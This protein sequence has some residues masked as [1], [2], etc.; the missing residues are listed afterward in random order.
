MIGRLGTARSLAVVD[1]LLPSR[2]GPPG[3]CLVVVTWH[4]ISLDHV[5]GYRSVDARIR[6]D[7]QRRSAGLSTWVTVSIESQLLDYCHDP[8]WVA[9][10][11]PKELLEHC[12]TGPKSSEL[13][14]PLQATGNR[15]S[16]EC[17]GVFLFGE[18]GRAR[19]GPIRLFAP[20]VRRSG[21]FWG[22]SR[23]LDLRCF[24]WFLVLAFA[25]FFWHPWGLTN[26]N[27][28]VRCII[29]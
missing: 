8:T 6:F 4:H 5:F 15:S 7:E 22:D 23:Y 3:R 9:S 14:E 12:Q 10:S 25:A 27:R 24:W 21:S 26:S 16:S 11:R 29:N 28:E 2:P 1:Q 19:V 18:G 17:L 13:T 20:I